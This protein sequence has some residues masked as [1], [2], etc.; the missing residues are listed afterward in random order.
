MSSRPAFISLA[1]LGLLLLLGS[2]I[3]FRLEMIHIARK[4][5]VLL[6]VQIQKEVAAFNAYPSK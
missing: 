4:E 3:A 2:L 6:R 1:L 5:N